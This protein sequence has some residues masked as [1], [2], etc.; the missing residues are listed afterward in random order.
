MF[1]TYSNISWF[2][3]NTPLPRSASTACSGGT[4]PSNKPHNRSPKVTCC[5]L[6]EV[7]YGRS[8]TPLC[9]LLFLLL[10]SVSILL[11]LLEG[12]VNVRPAWSMR[13][14]TGPPHI[15]SGRTCFV[16]ANICFGPRPSMRPSTIFGIGLRLS[17]L[18]SSKPPPVVLTTWP[19]NSTAC[20][21]SSGV[22]VCKSKTSIPI[23]ERKGIAVSSSSRCSTARS[24]FAWWKVRGRSSVYWESH[25]RKISNVGAR[26]GNDGISIFSVLRDLFRVV[27]ANLSTKNI[28]KL[29]PHMR[30]YLCQK[31]SIVLS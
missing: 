27:P 20:P 19:W 22:V 2:S 7:E 18:L 5:G 28:V 23:C 16:S 17:I 10:L 15:P 4:M 3:T 8:P 11:L 25:Q 12:K 1:S 14:T 31:S 24:R 26:E 9:E 21:T 6:G 13:H 30:V 29:L